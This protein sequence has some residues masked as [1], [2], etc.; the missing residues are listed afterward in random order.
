MTALC[1]VRVGCLCGG[2]GACRAALRVGIPYCI[3][4]PP[5]NKKRHFHP[6]LFFVL[7]T[8]HV[9]VGVSVRSQQPEIVFE[10]GLS[11]LPEN[12]F[13]NV[14]ISLQCYFATLFVPPLTT[15]SKGHLITFADFNLQKE[16]AVPCRAVP[17]PAG[18]LDSS[19]GAST[20]TE[21]KESTA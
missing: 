12:L 5:R 11:C 4:M 16:V 21:Q 18:P 15:T 1:S 7:K 10:H 8:F 20:S 14:S 19:D 6:L 9:G 13:Q 17:S 2:G 3:A